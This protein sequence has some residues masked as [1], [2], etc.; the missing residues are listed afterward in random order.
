ML[1]SPLSRST[2]TYSEPICTAVF[3]SE[4]IYTENDSKYV[5]EKIQYSMLQEKFKFSSLYQ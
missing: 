2:V 4:D 3:K 1:F 5:E